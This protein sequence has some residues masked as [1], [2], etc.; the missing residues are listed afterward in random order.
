[1]TIFCPAA[2]ELGKRTRQRPPKA[3]TNPPTHR[4]REIIKLCPLYANVGNGV[5]VVFLVPGPLWPRFSVFSLS[6]SFH[7]DSWHFVKMSL[8]QGC[9]VN[10]SY[11]RYMHYI[12]R[13]G[14]SNTCLVRT[15]P[16]VR[17]TFRPA[18]SVSHSLVERVFLS[19]LEFYTFALLWFCFFS[20][21]FGDNMVHIHTH[22]QVTGVTGTRGWTGL[23]L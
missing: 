13:R 3:P 16:Y 22:I 18:R 5:L 6:A 9:T 1:V 2:F 15:S 19:Y 8:V 11:S 7:S 17:L 10:C 4:N 12:S 21:L 20:L 14:S 23:Y